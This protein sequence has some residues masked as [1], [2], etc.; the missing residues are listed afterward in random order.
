MRY[1]QI[2]ELGDHSVSW[3]ILAIPSTSK[4]ITNTHKD[5]AI[6]KDTKEVT[7][8]VLRNA[9]DLDGLATDNQNVQAFSH[10][11]RGMTGKN[12]A[13]KR[14][15]LM[16]YT[17]AQ[18]GYGAQ[19]TTKSAQSRIADW[20]KDD[21]CDEYVFYFSGHGSRQGLCF[22][23]GVLGYSKL[24]EMLCKGMRGKVAKSTGIP[25]QVTVIIDA[26]FSGAVQ[27]AFKPYQKGPSNGGFLFQIFYS[28]QANETS[29]DTA[30][31]GGKFTSSLFAP[32]N[33]DLW[34]MYFVRGMVSGRLMKSRVFKYRA[35]SADKKSIVDKTQ[36]SGHMP[37]VVQK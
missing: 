15:K 16:S 14:V 18:S 28:S 5:R 33:Y 19:I 24:A 4:R 6:S 35:L 30:E 26:C 36:T 37:C 10:K 31:F 20:L 2:A 13:G 32:Q 25:K 21:Q 23:D 12:Y 7:A 8:K 1:Q 17:H 9:I 11:L 29:A 22:K 3:L 34:F 27:G